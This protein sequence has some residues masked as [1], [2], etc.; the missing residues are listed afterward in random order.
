MKRF[1]LE[2]LVPDSC[3]C[4]KGM[5]E[6]PDGKYVL[7][8]DA[9]EEIDRITKQPISD[10]IQLVN[11]IQEYLLHGGLFN[12]E[13]AIHENVRDLLMDI[14]EYL[15]PETKEIDKRCK[16][17]VFLTHRCRDCEQEPICEKDFELFKKQLLGSEDIYSKHIVEIWTVGSLD[18]ISYVIIEPYNKIDN[19]WWAINGEYI[20]IP[21][22]EKSE[23]YL[24][25]TKI[26]HE[27]HYL[28]D[29]EYTGNYNETIN[30]YKDTKKIIGFNGVKFKEQLKPT[31]ETDE[32][33]F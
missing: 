7:Y 20:V 23:V 5:V 8:N 25:Y 21:N 12:P 9:K 24:P 31:V 2:Y 13:L 33:P 27:S 6:R 28:G 14:L 1:N 10:N 11:R 3:S 30:N 19:S 16:H 18:S 26:T 32:P 22:K 4:P 17:G 29:V 15:K